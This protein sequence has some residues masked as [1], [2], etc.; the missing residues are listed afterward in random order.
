MR[1]TVQYQ[2]YKSFSV[3]D[4]RTTM[5][6]IFYLWCTRASHLLSH[7]NHM[8]SKHLHVNYFHVY[9]YMRLVTNQHEAAT[10]SLQNS[11]NATWHRFYKSLKLYWRDEKQ[12]WAISPIINIT[13]NIYLGNDE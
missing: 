12:A 4:T 10:A 1:A 7:F 5:I 2:G 13:I 6:Y 8:S 11:S 3:V 9:L